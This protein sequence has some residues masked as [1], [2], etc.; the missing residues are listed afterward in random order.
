MERHTINNGYRS[1]CLG[2]GLCKGDWTRV[3]Q[4]L[5][6]LVVIFNATAHSNGVVF[7]ALLLAGLLYLK[8]DNLRSGLSSEVV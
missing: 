6:N 7:F 5:H 1:A 8:T 2:N 4:C 3:S